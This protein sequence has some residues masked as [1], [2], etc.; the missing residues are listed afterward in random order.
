MEP[1]VLNSQ[2]ELLEQTENQFQFGIHQRLT[3]NPPVEDGNTHDIFPV[4]NG[5]SHLAAE[6]FKFLARFRIG[7]SLFTISTQ[8]SAES[9]EMSANAPVKG[10]LEMFE[11]P[12]GKADGRC[13]AQSA[14]LVRRG[15]FF[16]WSRRNS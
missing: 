7:S 8:N 10:E 15:R 13:S 6:Q 1:D 5:D 12:G 16:K 4:Q 11:Q 9:K 3:G 14:R 2:A